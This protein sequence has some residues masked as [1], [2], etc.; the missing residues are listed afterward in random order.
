MEMDL[1]SLYGN[2]TL[3]ILGDYQNAARIKKN[4]KGFLPNHEHES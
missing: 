1:I 4:Q 3:S 2:V